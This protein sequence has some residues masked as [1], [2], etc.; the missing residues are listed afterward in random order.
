[1]KGD[2]RY[3]PVKDGKLYC[4]PACGNGCT[5]AAYLKAKDAAAK[6]CKQLG[7][8]WKPRVWENLGW[9][10]EAVL[11]DYVMHVHRIISGA[12]MAQLRQTKFC[13]TAKTPRAAIHKALDLAQSAVDD[14]LRDIT[15]AQ[16]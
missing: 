10:H 5:Y 16:L 12:Y 3:A 8:K 1:M 2:P 4:S 15:E 7:Q 13:A 6:L 11:G 14:L 9:Y